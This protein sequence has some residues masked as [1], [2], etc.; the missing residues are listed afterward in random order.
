MLN[1]AGEVFADVPG[2]GLLHVGLHLAGFQDCVSHHATHADS[3]MVGSTSHLPTAPPSLIRAVTKA[4]DDL[5]DK[6][7]LVAQELL[8]PW[9]PPFYEDTSPLYNKVVRHR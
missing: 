5:R 3:V 1:F 7:D 8:D 6:T 2:V 9:L 4:A